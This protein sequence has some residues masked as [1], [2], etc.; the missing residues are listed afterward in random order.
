[1]PTKE[2][3]EYGALERLGFTPG[4]AK[5][6]LALLELG[7]TTTGPLIIKS[8]VSRSK[9]YE[10]LERLEAKGLATES[11]RENI[12]YFQPTTPLRLM[13]Y[14]KRKKEALLEEEA[15][16]KKVLPN[17]VALQ[18]SSKYEQE[19]RVYTGF[20]GIK[21]IYNEV[22]E[23]LPTGGEY[24]ALTFSDPTLQSE[25]ITRFFRK[26]HQQRA[27]KKIRARILANISDRQVQGKM[28]Y[29]DTGYYEFRLTAQKTPHGFAIF[30]DTVIIFNWGRQP[31]AFA[32]VCKENAQGYRDF[33]NSLWAQAKKK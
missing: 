4:E 23:Q 28:N 15:Q 6:Y 8:G 20:E 27:G 1:M 5:T 17:L 18:K 3:M 14:L 19:A 29:S 31:R 13:D 33:F 21:T 30:N 12:R 2:G 11:I 24:L 7:S 25:E 22:L 26:F 9:V 10:V 16:L 32:I